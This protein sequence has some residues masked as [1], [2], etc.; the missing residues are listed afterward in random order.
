M[1]VPLVA[2]GLGA[3]VAVVLGVYGGVH[4]PSGETITTFG[5]GS[6]LAMKVWLALVAGC[7]AVVQLVTALWM[8]GRFG[9]PAP[10]VVGVVHRAS[11][12]L[13]V[14]VSLPVA[15]HCLWS[16]G[17]E[18]ADTRVLLHSLLG[19]AF[20]GAFAAKVTIVRSKGLPGIA[21]PLAGGTV[22]ALLVFVWL[23]SALWFIN[24]NGFPSL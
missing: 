7:F 5:F 19:C 6:M 20:Y 16:I 13:A 9:R 11:G 10:P 17:F 12:L 2:I 3:A 8:F 24:H 18:S 21:L 23:T 14:L 15:Y 4:T 22:F 1:V